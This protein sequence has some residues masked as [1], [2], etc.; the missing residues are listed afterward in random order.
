MFKIR[1]LASGR[2]PDMVDHITMPQNELAYGRVVNITGD[3]L[4]AADTTDSVFGILM[5]DPN[6]TIEAG[7]G[8]NF[9]LAASSTADVYPVVH[10]I[11]ADTLIEADVTGTVVNN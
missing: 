11:Y 1:K 4:E 5:S 8:V 9:P 6:Q 2:T 10:R 7:G 3:E